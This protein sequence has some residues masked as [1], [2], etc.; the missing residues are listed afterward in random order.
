ME[1]G[2][3][4]GLVIIFREETGEAGGGVAVGERERE[5]EVKTKRFLEHRMIR[6]RMMLKGTGGRLTGF[7]EREDDETQ[8]VMKGRMTKHKCY[9]REDDETQDVMRGRMTKHKVL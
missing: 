3:V 6:E 5:M 9:E 4:S 1:R 2:G 8:G 7:Y